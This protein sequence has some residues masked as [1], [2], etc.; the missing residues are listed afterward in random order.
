MIHTT[1]VSLEEDELSAH[2]AEAAEQS[3]IA[4]VRF[5]PFPGS[6]WW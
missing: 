4:F 3:L 5:T 1:I 6:G 2:G